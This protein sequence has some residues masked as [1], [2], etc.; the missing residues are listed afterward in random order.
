MPLE[1]TLKRI[2]DKLKDMSEEDLKKWAEQLE[3]DAKQL[4]LTPVT[5]KTGLMLPPEDYDR[6]IDKYLDKVFGKGSFR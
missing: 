3:Q 5:S 1:E 2:A 4:C 6:E